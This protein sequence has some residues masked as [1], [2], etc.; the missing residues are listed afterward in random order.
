MSVNLFLYIDPGTGS[1]LFSVIIGLVTTLY[2]VSKAA[3]IKMKTLFL[4]RSKVLRE[5]KRLPLV[6]YNEG[7][8]YSNVFKPVLDELEA[9]K[10]SAVYYT[11]A[12]NDP[13]FDTPWHFIRAEYIGKGN[14][15]VARLNFLEADVC[16]MTTPALDVYQMKRSKGV[17]HYSHILHAVD[18][19]T[20]YRLFGLDYFDS[21]L[22]SGEYQKKHIRELEAKRDIPAKDLVVVGCPYLDVL[23][24][25]VA[26]LEAEKDHTFTVLVAPS[27]GESA[28]LSKYGT[29]LLDPLMKTGFRIIIRP[30]P[31]SVASEAAMLEKLKVRYP[32]TERMIWDFS[33]ENLIP[34]SKS[35]IMISDFSGVIFDYVFLFDRPFLYVN[36]N[37]DLRPYDAFDVEEAPWKFR[38]LGEI[39]RELTEDQFDNLGPILNSLAKDP[40][41]AGKRQE[42]KNTAWQHVGE[43]GKRSADYLEGIVSQLKY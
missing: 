30:H 32:E 6:L 42:A 22:L 15:A 31:Q 13:V 14:K 43:S 33:R 38:I 1:M 9:R 17:R 8:Q 26:S 21:V 12:E 2:F 4:G 29:R 28:L 25:K 39:G 23:K 40:L 11:S 37:F 24:T 41:L 34:L 16:L 3:F 35:D 18:D 36:Q 19:A 10:V 20:S 7:I 27:W 5:K